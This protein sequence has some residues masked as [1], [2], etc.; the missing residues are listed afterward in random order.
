[1]K[2]QFREYFP[3]LEEELKD[4]WKDCI[5]IFDT[6]VLLN[7]YRYTEKA[8]NDYIRVFRTLWKEDR[9]YLPYHVWWE[10]FENRRN[11]LNSNKK[12]Y[13]TICNSLR[14]ELETIKK[15]KDHPML[16]LKDIT[17][18]LQE[19]IDDIQEKEKDHPDYNWEKDVILVEIT[20]IFDWKIWEKPTTDYSEKVEKEWLERYKKKI[21]PWFEDDKKPTNK[22]WDYF[23]WKEILEKWKTS[24]KSIVFITDDTKEDWW[25]RDEWKTIM[26]HPSLRREFFECAGTDFHMYT[27]ENFLNHIN[28]NQIN[29]N[30]ELNID[31]D[32]IAEVKKV[33]DSWPRVVKSN[34]EWIIKEFMLCLEALV[35]GTTFEIELD[36][37]EKLTQLWIRI[38]SKKNV[39]SIDFYN[40]LEESIESIISLSTDL[41]E[42]YR[43]NLKAKDPLRIAILKFRE[44]LRYTSNKKADFVFQQKQLLIEEIGEEEMI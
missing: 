37:R 11:V 17:D 32:T 5:F 4:I 35:D 12:H 26:P 6:N 33:W 31:K 44:L 18:R 1:M 21:P 3:L 15:I 23:V 41:Y 39:E 28:D 22:F 24:K 10:F 43:L 25:L 38:S 29:K 7:M 8:R 16:D 19:I 27:P 36:E 14:K 9:L 13:S 2:K 30:T 20:S 40:L 42:K 34:I